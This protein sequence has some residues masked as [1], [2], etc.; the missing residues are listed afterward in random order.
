[1]SEKDKKAGQV[2]KDNNGLCETISCGVCLKEVPV[3][4]AH[5]REGDDYVLNFCGI[6]CHDKWVH[7][8]GLNKSQHSA[9]DE[10]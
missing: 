6:E 1:M 5:S 3:S 10:H 9:S 2:S 8:N 4:V 7:Q